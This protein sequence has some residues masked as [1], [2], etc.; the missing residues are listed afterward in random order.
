MMW[1]FFKVWNLV[2]QS[3][4]VNPKLLLVWVCILYLIAPILKCRTCL[5]FLWCINWKGYFK[6]SINTSRKVKKIIWSSPNWLTSWK[7]KLLKN[8]KIRWISKFNLIQRFMAI[9]K[10]ILVNM[11]L[12]MPISYN[13]FWRLGWFWHSIV[14]FFYIFS[15]LTLMHSFQSNFHEQNIS[16]FANPSLQ[17]IFVK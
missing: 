3:K 1:M 7:L 12:D 11:G 6:L 5:F 2:L 15:M 14:T 13:Q 9:Y 17:S 10:T 4:F 8:D 16:L